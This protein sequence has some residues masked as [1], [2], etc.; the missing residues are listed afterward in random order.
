MGLLFLPKSPRYFVKRGAHQKAAQSLARL[1]GQPED[2]D[3]I[4]DELTEIIANHEYEMNAIGRETGYIQS[5]LNCF[6]GSLSD[7]GSNIRRT[8]LGTSAQMMQQWTGINFI[9][10]FGTV[11]FQSLSKSSQASSILH[12]GLDTDKSQIQSRTPF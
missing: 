1:R 2:S 8:I 10:Y 7:P 6:K 11:F 4:R 3:F 12:V 9:F 5:W